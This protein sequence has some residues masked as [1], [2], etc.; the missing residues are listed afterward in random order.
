MAPAL[1][2][3]VRKH[4]KQSLIICR[5]EPSREAARGLG[6]R[7]RGGADTAWTFEPAPLARGAQLLR[8]AG[9]DG[10]RSCSWSARSIRSGGR[11]SPTCS[12][13]PRTSF[14]GQFRASTTSR[15]T[16]TTGRTTRPRRYDAYLDGARRGRA[17]RS[18][19]SAARSWRSSAWR[20][21]TAP[22]AKTGRAPAD[23]GAG[24]R[25]RRARHV[26]ARQR[27]AQ[28]VAAGQLALSRD[29][30]VD[31]GR[32]AV[33]RRHDGRAHPQPDARPRPRR[34]PAARRRRGARRAA[35]AGAAPARP[36]GRA[37]AARGAWR[38]CRG[39]S[40][41]W[42]RWAS[43]SRT[44][45]SACIPSFPR[46]T[47]RGASST[48]FRRCRPSLQRLDGRARMSFVEAILERCAR[49]GRAGRCCT[50]CTATRWSPRVGPRTCW[51]RSRARAASCARAASTPGDRVALLGAELGALG[52]GRPGDPG[53]GRD[54]RAAVRAPGAAR[55]RRHAARLHA[56]AAA[57]R[58]RRAAPPRSRA[59]GPSTARVARY[60]EVFAA[61]RVD[62][63]RASS[64]RRGPVT[65]IYTSG[66]SGEPKGVLLDRRQR[67]LHARRHRARA[68][69]D[70][71]QG[72]SEDRVFHYLPFCFAGSRD[73]AAQP[74]RSA[75]TR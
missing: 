21:S 41:G 6:I 49:R 72:A 42:G 54:L 65:I 32:R 69:E 45:C 64:A 26:R 47:C 62:R 37:R 4:C 17:A 48:S 74:A 67:R 38:S 14:G 15:S 20:C 73:H 31:A 40:G 52:R 39:R 28:R 24:V 68:V 12:R 36:R 70:G 3:F 2:D 7:T 1:R 5:N 22:R 9:W 57:R 19:R 61:R 51:R 53:R 18:R 16:S 56:R 43:T 66:T 60:D 29:R 8:A 27:A 10:G 13:R 11:S 33:D 71:G 44:R 34:V 58:G 30:D 75:A 25:Q 50:R 46:A 23:A 63:R 55:A 59:R 35:A